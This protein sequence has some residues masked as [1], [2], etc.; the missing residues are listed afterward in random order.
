MKKIFFF[1]FILLAGM[2]FAQAQNQSETLTIKAVKKGEEPEKV[3]DAIKADFPKAI[4]TDL[5]IL[6]AKLYGEYWS[7]SLNDNLGG[8]TPD[9]YL[10][11]LKETNEVYK[12]VYDKDGKIKSSKL[13][14]K[15]A[16]LPADVTSTIAIK[17][18]DW[19]IIKDLEKITNKEGKIKEVYHVG[20]EKNKMHRSLF[21]DSGGKLI[22]DVPRKS[23]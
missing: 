4:V 14:I 15:Q 23:S 22:K 19:T 8:K 11:N 10:V 20:I 21:L 2:K 16:Q 3:M 6:P 17:Y 5:S 1:C 18:P 12:A 13:I 9:L 7:V